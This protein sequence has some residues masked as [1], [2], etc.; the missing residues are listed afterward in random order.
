MPEMDVLDFME[1]SGYEATSRRHTTSLKKCFAD[2]NQL[3]A[4]PLPEWTG[5]KNGV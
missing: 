4:E 2:T 3:D 5:G 1:L